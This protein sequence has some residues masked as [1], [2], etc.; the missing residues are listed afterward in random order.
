MKKSDYQLID[1]GSGKKLERFGDYLI[2]RPASQAAWLPQKPKATWKCSHAQF[3]REDD[4]KWTNLD[5]LPEEW[6][7]TVSDIQFKL[8]PTDFGHLGIFPEQT[9][10]WQWAQQAIR[11]ENS[12]RDTPLR[13]LN[14]FAYSGGS[15][16]AA[17]K[18]GAEVVHLDA[19]KGMVAWARDNAA[20]NG[21]KEAPI[22][23]IT[24]DV[25]KFINRELRRG[26]RYDAIIL[27]PPTFGRGTKGE[28]FKIEEEI[29]PL[30]QS[31]RQLLTENPLFVMLSCH[32]P[33]YTP[34]VLHHL[35]EQSVDNLGGGIVT[36]EMFLEG[37]EFPLPSGA[38]A[39]WYVHG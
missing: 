29:V 16:L 6:T 3:T 14:L 27:D 23:W 32:T 39:R 26:N 33:G 36:G 37:E 5:G 24:D 15:T 28:L 4:K 19:S 2:E 25:T 8:S 1:S 17:A 12:K 21:L 20:I 9:P 22:R 13:V 35:L 30:L 18:G 10:F 7:I 31:C 11:E 38:Y 34:T